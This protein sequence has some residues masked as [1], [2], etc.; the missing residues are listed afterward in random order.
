MISDTI[1]RPGSLQCQ[2]E[3][4]EVGN[5]MQKVSQNQRRQ[6][7]EIQDE[8]DDR[9]TARIPIYQKQRPQRRGVEINLDRY[10]EAP[11]DVAMYEDGHDR[12]PPRRRNRLS[13]PLGVMATRALAEQKRGNALLAEI[14]RELGNRPN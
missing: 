6:Y 4:H 13:V 14:L 2:S 8:R 3:R 10:V 12:N 1:I 5:K 7:S 11:H 9:A